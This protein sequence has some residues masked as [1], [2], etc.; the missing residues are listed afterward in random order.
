VE[1]GLAVDSEFD[2]ARGLRVSITGLE[3]ADKLLSDT[4][5]VCEE[6]FRCKDWVR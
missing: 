5:L 3:T 1:S 2:M 6:D 4:E